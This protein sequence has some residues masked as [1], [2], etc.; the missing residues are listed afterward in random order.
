MH[1]RPGGLRALTNAPALLSLSR[2]PLAGCFYLLVAVPAAAFAV[3]II[4]GVT[5]VLDG[6]LAR[7][8]GLVSAAGAVLD[9]ITDKLFV[10][11]VAV[12]MVAADKLSLLDILWLSMRELGELPLVLWFV[13]EPRARA[14]RA[15][16]PGA[17]L[18]G[19]LATVLQFLA[20]GWAL[21]QWPGLGLWLGVTACAGVLA[22]VSYWRRALRSVSPPSGSHPSSPRPSG[23]SP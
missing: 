5:D 17:N 7:R 6:W 1:V 15:E 16:H 4:A 2:I 19:K 21:F 10:L 12:T 14:A 11:T 20:V 9:P 3:L 23:R 8:R 13:L 18:P 22:A